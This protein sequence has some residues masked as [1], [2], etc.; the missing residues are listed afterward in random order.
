MALTLIDQVR[1]EIGLVGAAYTIFSDEEISHYLLQNN[2]NVKRTG[3]ELAVK[4]CFILSQYVHTKADVLEEW[5]HDWFNNYYK[6]LQMYLNNPNYS[7][8]LDSARPY[9]GGISVTDILENVNNSDNFVVSVEVGI[10]TDGDAINTT[11]TNRQVFKR[12]PNTF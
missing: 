12:F 10:P 6:S 7:F 4:V 9:A 2:N 8:A 5:G 11:N 3:K 1:L